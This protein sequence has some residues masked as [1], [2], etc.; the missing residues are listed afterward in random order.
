MSNPYKQLI[1]LIPGQRVETGEVI[2]VRDDGVI[3]ELPTG[4]HY[5]ARGAAEVGDTVYV[6][7]GAVDGPAPVLAG[8]EITV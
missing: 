5:F 6:K 1:A 2:A 3:I 4:E 7:D 8:T